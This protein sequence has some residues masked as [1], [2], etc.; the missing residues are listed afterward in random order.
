V[1]PVKAAIETVTMQPKYKAPSILKKTEYYPP[2]AP[3][4]SIIKKPKK[5]AE[6]EVK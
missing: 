6:E 4:T 3:L 2:L 5:V 1:E